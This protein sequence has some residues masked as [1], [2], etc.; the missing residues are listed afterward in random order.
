MTAIGDRRDW[1][2]SIARYLS[3]SYSIDITRFRV[4]GGKLKKT[5]QGSQSY[6]GK[7]ISESLQ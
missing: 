3:K 7:G 6:Q 5:D 4:F 1:M 2:R